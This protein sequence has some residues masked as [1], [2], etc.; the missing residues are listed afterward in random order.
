MQ[1]PTATATPRVQATAAV[2]QRHWRYHRVHDSHQTAST[3]VT[4]RYHCH[5]HPPVT[6]AVQQRRSRRRQQSVP[7]P[8]PSPS[9]LETWCCVGVDPDCQLQHQ[10]LACYRTHDQHRSHARHLA[11]QSHGEACHPEHRQY[12]PFSV[13]SRQMHPQNRPAFR[14]HCL[15]PPSDVECERQRSTPRRTR[16][17]SR[18]RCPVAAR[19][20]GGTSRRQPVPRTPPR[21][22]R[23]SRRRPRSHCAHRP[24]T[25]TWRRAGTRTARATPAACTPR[26]RRTASSPHRRSR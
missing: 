18:R 17:R 7:S 14:A 5:W 13:E 19:E 3:R 1:H 12:R 26:R 21:T 11:C 24:S 22:R 9:W 25:T 20:H 16:R 15:P 2:H 8:S 4:C 10:R 6:T 23:R